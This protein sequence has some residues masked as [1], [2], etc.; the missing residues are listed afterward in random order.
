LLLL[1]LGA[2]VGRRLGHVAGEGGLLPSLLWELLLL[3]WLLSPRGSTRWLGALT[4][5]GK[6]RSRRA[7]AETTRLELAKSKPHVVDSVAAVC[8]NDMA[9]NGVAI[10]IRA[11]VDGGSEAYRPEFGDI[12]SSRNRHHGVQFRCQK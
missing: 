1:L 8:G 5:L 3:L 12:R 10:P 6:L 2:S 9:T 4:P 11:A 7:G